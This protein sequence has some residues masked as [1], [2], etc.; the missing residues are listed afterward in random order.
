MDA[1]KPLLFVGNAQGE[2]QQLAND[3]ASRGWSVQHAND[4]EQASAA[5]HKQSCD[6]GLV[7]IDP[8]HLP[9][10][11]K[12][13]EL[14]N[15]SRTEWVA[16]LDPSA[17]V[18]DGVLRL[19]NRIF[20]AYHT[21][22]ANAEGLD[23]V[24]N[25]AGAMARLSPTE[26]AQNEPPG[27]EYEMVGSTHVMRELFANI[28]KIANVDAPVLITGESGTGKELAARAIHER[29]A[30]AKAPFNAVNCA[31]LPDNLIQSELFGHEKGSFTG[32]NQRKVGHIEATAGGTIFLD[33]IGD[34]PLD[35][36]VNLLRF[37]EGHSIQR[38]GSTQEITVDVRVLAATHVN[39][40]K[41]VAEKRFREDLYHRLNVLT[42]KT[43]PLREREEDIELLARFFFSKFR[44]ENNSRVGGLS[45][46]ALILIRRYEW[47]GNVRE[48]INRVRRATVMCEGR[49]I[50]PMD[51][52][53]ER[54]RSRRDVVTLEQAR[55]SAEKDTILAALR[56]NRQ[57]VSQAANE[58]GVSRVTLY[59]LLEKYQIPPSKKP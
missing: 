47:P 51:L 33:E 43:P 42:V 10:P 21:L 6:V 30:R 34:L 13:D 35:L 44:N 38:V 40:E 28:R 45:E 37:L 3:I 57:N 58:L 25:H 41:A 54:R 17:L 39:L 4:W 19:L 1:L 15:G 55:E 27:D 2:L 56:R 5:L 36:Q 32:A 22:P 53:L 8:Q 23:C 49:L 29:S 48:L 20:F 50:Q 31:A 14:L 12:I 11:G 18:N 46:Q 7:Y 9:R 24:L 52:G 16:L 26:I 59:R